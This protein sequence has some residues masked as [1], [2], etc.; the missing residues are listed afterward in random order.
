MPCAIRVEDPSGATSHS[1]ATRT[2]QR[3]C[4]TTSRSRQLRGPQKLQRGLQRHAV[5]GETHRKRIVPRAD[6]P[7]ISAFSPIGKNSPAVIPRRCG[8]HT[9]AP[10]SGLRPRPRTP[11]SE[12]GISH[13][14]RNPIGLGHSASAIQC[15]VD[16]ARA[17]GV[18]RGRSAACRPDSAGSSS[19]PFATPF[20][21]RSH[22]R[23]ASCK[24]PDLR[25]PAPRVCGYWCTQG[26]MIPF[27]GPRAG[28]RPAQPR[29]SCNCRSNRR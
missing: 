21:Q 4:P 12:N 17:A 19:A 15:P 25:V 2:A 20:N 5:G 22:Q 3:S 28:S 16:D 9:T 10:I 6:P 29:C 26:P 11:A 14:P 1:R 18:R 7:P 23:T 27:T 24:K 8:V 13:V